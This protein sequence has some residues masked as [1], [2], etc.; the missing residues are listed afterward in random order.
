MKDGYQIEQGLRED[1]VRM[2]DRL[3]MDEG[4]INQELI[5]DRVGTT[6][7]QSKDNVGIKG[8]WSKDYG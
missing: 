1:R 5:S 8:G 7:G 3:S 4:W 6:G 2:K